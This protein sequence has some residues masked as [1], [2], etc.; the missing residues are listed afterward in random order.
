MP[1]QETTEQQPAISTGHI[2]AA[3][4]CAAL[5]GIA[6]LVLALENPG[7]PG[8]SIIQ[9]GAVVAALIGVTL[10]ICGLVLVVS[11]RFGD[12]YDAAEQAASGYRER[13]DKGLAC[14]ET[15]QG[16]ILVALR[17]IGEQT[18]RLGKQHKDIEATLSDCQAAVQEC[19]EALDGVID[20][21][22]AAAETFA[23]TG[24]FRLSQAKSREPQ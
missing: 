12:R 20:D 22:D 14:I 21:F 15:K 19:R 13:V 3:C 17:T 4:F 18:R 24:T 7:Q 16:Q 1:D 5:V 2:I 9:V 6:V 8:R 11:K 10:V 23:E